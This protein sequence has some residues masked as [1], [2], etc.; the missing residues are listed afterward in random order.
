MPV[1]HTEFE[2]RLSICDEQLDELFQD[3]IQSPQ[4]KQKTKAVRDYYNISYFKASQGKTAEK[5]A[6]NYEFFIDQLR[7]V[8]N[9][10]LSYDLAIKNI[11]HSSESRKINV[12]FC[13]LAKACELIFWTACTLSL[14][15]G[16]WG[17]ALPA[18]IL[19]P[20][21]GIALSITIVGGMLG[22]ANKASS[23]LNEFKSFRRHDAEYT[24]EASLV[25]LFKHEPRMQ[26]NN[27]SVADESE[28]LEPACC[29]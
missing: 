15:A 8:K 21:L 16:I 5:I 24:N 13:N 4:L 3:Q 6:T 9:N 20:T 7:K 17:I 23:C 12:L 14:L 27:A 25:S 28:E 1:N 2:Q 18:L 29:F 19:Q 10:E 26:E 22:A 11:E